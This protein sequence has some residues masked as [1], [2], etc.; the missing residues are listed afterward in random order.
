MTSRRWS[1]LVSGLVLTLALGAGGP[2]RAQFGVSGISGYPSVSPYGLGYASGIGYGAT[3]YDYGPYG[4]L[5][6]GGF[7]GIGVF[8]YPGYDLASGLTPQ[9]TT[10]FPSISNVVTAVPGWS[11]SAHRVRRRLQ[12]R[13]NVARAPLRR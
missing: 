1:T 10:A 3:P 8:P 5:G 13:P 9:T 4:G 7:G 11:G 12:A 6:Y 2:A